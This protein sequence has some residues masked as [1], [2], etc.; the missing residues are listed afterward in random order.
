MTFSPSVIDPNSN[1]SLGIDLPCPKCG[2]EPGKR[3]VTPSG[4]RVLVTHQ[5]RFRA[6]L[7]A[8]GSARAWFNEQMTRVTA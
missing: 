4:N 1:A 6:A 5:A 8:D 7:Y 2:A 3:C